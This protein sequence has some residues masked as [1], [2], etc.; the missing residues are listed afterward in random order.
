VANLRF[1]IYVIISP[2]YA[3]LYLLLNT[4]HLLHI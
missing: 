3:T 2:K 1:Y 4:L